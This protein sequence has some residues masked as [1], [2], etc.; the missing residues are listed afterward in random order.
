MERTKPRYTVRPESCQRGKST[1]V[2]HPQRAV[3]ADVLGAHRTGRWKRWFLTLT[4]YPLNS[5]DEAYL[6]MKFPGVF[7]GAP[8]QHPALAR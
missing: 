7:S 3:F 6:K 5:L 1:V 2:D 4:G 8:L